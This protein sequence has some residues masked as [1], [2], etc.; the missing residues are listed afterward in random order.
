MADSI[1]VRGVTKDIGKALDI[2]AE[3]HKVIASNIANLDTPGYK[4][5]EIDFKKA[6]YSA[7]NGETTKMACTNDR[8]IGHL[9][10][11]EAFETS[12]DS[13]SA[14]NGNNWVDIDREMTKLAENNLLYRTNVEALLRKLNLIKQVIIDGGR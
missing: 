8:H 2:T 3:R 4:A 11:N 9:D 10:P 14:F 12:F 13:Q 6:L 1:I 7:M 5:N